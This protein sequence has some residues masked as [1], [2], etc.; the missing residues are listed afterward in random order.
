[1][2]HVLCWLLNDRCV[3]CLENSHRPNLNVLFAMHSVL[4]LLVQRF[5]H[6]NEA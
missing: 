6:S 4:Y 3:Y 5:G 2:P 1:M